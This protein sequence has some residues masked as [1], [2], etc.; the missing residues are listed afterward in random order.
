MMQADL[1]VNLAQSVSTDIHHLKGA[2]VSDNTHVLTISADGGAI[3]AY[4][5]V[6]QIE[7]L[8]K[9]CLDYVQQYNAEEMVAAVRRME[10][11]AAA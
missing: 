5:T 7:D 9:A 10:K 2:S 1:H 11:G 6:E 8:G 3:K 4:M